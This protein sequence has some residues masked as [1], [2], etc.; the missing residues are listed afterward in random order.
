M[1]LPVVACDFAPLHGF[2]GPAPLGCRVLVPWRGDLIVGL[3]VGAGDGRGAHRLREVVHMLDDPGRPWVAPATVQ[4]I[5]EWGRD[6]R[7]PAGLI[8]GDLLG[9]GWAAA[10]VHLVRAVDDADLS[11]FARKVP[12]ARWTDAE[13]F[14]PALLDAIREQGLLEERFTPQPRLKTVVQARALAEVPPASR[15]VTLVQA[16]APPPASL[17]PKQ[18]QACAWL[19]EHGPADTLSAWARGAGLSN[20][21]VT[22]ALNAGAPPTC[23]PRPRRP[24]PGH[25]CTSG[26]RRVLRRL[27]QWRQRRR[28]SPQPH[29]G[30]HPGPARLGRHAG[31]A[32]PAPAAA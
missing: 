4:G 21:V 26:G 8:W 19:R 24:R 1:N 18:A 6:A 12:G 31:G 28:H 17:T 9:V 32:G 22:A 2:Q 23:V 29:P 5:G 20:S 16:V 13:H 30:R 11:P 10:Y 14:P 7:L 25:G 15:L 3:V 27:G